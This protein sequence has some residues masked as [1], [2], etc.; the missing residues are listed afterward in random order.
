MI[1]SNYLSRRSVVALGLGVLALQSAQSYAAK[2]E[3]VVQ[4]DWNNGFVASIRITNN[5]SS[6]I[7]GW[8][9]N[10]NYSDGSSRSGGWNA[11]V[12]GGNP[13]TATG[14]GWN[15]TINPGQAVEFGIQGTKGVGS[16]P[17]SKPVVSG[18]V[19]DATPSSAVSSVTSTAS[20]VR[21]SSLSSSSQTSTYTSMSSSLRS[22]SSSSYQSTSFPLTSSSTSSSY[23]STSISSS[24]S[25]SS[26]SYASSASSNS[27]SLA[28]PTANLFVDTHGL[29]VFVDA[30]ASSDPLNRPLQHIISFGDSES[31]SHSYGWHTYT[32][33]GE[34]EISVKVYTATSVA[35]AETK[36]VVHV[37]PSAEA[38][39]APIAMLAAARSRSYLSAWGSA[40]FDEDGDPLQYIWDFGQGEFVGDSS[41]YHYDC[42]NSSSSN[43]SVSNSVSSRAKVVLTVSDGTLADTKSLTRS[44]NCN[45][46]EEI[47]PIPKINAR[48]DGL[49]VYVDARKSESV[50]GVVWD[51]GDGTTSNDLITAHTYAA[52]G[53][54]Q[55]K[56]TGLSNVFTRSI[57]QPVPVGSAA[58]ASSV[59]RSST[60]SSQASISSSSLQSSSVFSAIPSSI[61]ASSSA[62]SSSTPNHY[63]APKA[64]VAP[65]I[66]GSAEPLWNNASWSPI[67]VFWLGTQPNPTLG[68]YNGRYK[69]VW[70]EEY[71]YLLFEVVDDR[72]FDGVSDPLDR[73]WEDDTVELFIDENHNGGQHGYNTSAW[74][75]HVSTLGD[76]V[77]Y[78]TSGPKLLNDHIQVARGMSANNLHT[79]ELRI[80][81]Y[82]EDYA[83]WKTNTPLALYAGKLMGFSAAYID[84]DGSPQRESMMGSVD[85]RGHKNNEG[86]LDASVFGT[87]LLVE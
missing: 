65:V 15:N 82:G 37:S 7:N 2:C 72:L 12:S 83:D 79:W 22:N 39:R 77:D 80:K 21:P 86:Y 24:S 58:S 9:V 32:T 44:T 30:R 41:E 26:S 62:Q 18:A 53:E 36:Q 52:A 69:A 42:N 13:Y 84:N 60:P 59:A 47:L 10:W 34:Y 63:N 45:L 20:S 40:S 17:A 6:V 49:T 71:L 4:S 64:V 14:V 8:S 54:Y 66:D 74:A 48:V 50:T 76:V 28:M 43:S 5:T 11:N 35:T 70:T 61:P 27:S 25:V 46:I 73:Y 57:I 56:L 68:D 87:M 51:F 81:I 1:F 85:T 55:L 75:Y 29:T 19:C 33:P 3:Y 31:L 67:N 23:Q 16:A 78:T 38:N